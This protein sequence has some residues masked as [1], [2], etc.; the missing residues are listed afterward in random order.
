M[1]N[2]GKLIDADVELTSE[3]GKGTAITLTYHYKKESSTALDNEVD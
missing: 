2:R 3:K 1:Q